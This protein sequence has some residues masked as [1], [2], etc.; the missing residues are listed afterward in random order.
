MKKNQGVALITG[1]SSGIGLEMARLLAK[2]GYDLLLVSR[3]AERLADLA[4]SLQSESGV[5]AHVCAIDLAKAGSARDLFDFTKE[6][7]LEVELLI[8][9]AGVGHFGEHL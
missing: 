1:A 8:N 2:R 3:N 9:N 4:E 5:A 7:G 6:R